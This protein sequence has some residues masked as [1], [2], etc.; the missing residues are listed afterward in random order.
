MECPEVD[1]PLSGTKWAA[2]SEAYA[3]VISEHLHPRAM[4]LDAGCGLHLLE[5][6]MEPLEKWLISHCRLIVGMDVSVT[7]RSNISVLVRGC[8]YALPFADNSFD[9]VTCNMVVEHL[10]NPAR[11]FAEVARCLSPGGAFIVTT[12][13]LLNYGIIGNSVASKVMPEKW[14]LRLVH[15]SD[16][17]DP[18]DVFPVRYKA[19]TMRHLVRLLD[20]SG[21]LVHKTITL[22]QRG[23]FLRKTEKLERLL[24]KLTPTSG[25]LVCA[26]KRLGAENLHPA[27]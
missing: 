19:N 13:N 24:M 3:A 1:I 2:K 21:L 9:L 12:P 25:L 27:A 22:S 6:D 7:A 4:W 8:L 10:D 14:R 16:G 20:D 15:G 11:A 17:R 18:K 26:H 23:P 5:N